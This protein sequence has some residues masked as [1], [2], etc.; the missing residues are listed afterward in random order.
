MSGLEIAG[1]I[2]AAPP[3]LVSW[4]EHYR[5]V[6]EYLGCWKKFRA[7]YRQCQTQ[8]QN[9]E[10]SLNFTLE[11]LYLPF[12]ES[13][14][15]LERLKET[16]DDNAWIEVETKLRLRLIKDAQPGYLGGLKDLKSAIQE[17]R[18]ELAY[19]NGCF[20][21][22]L[23]QASQASCQLSLTY[24]YGIQSHGPPNSP[25][26]FFEKAQ[27]RLIGSAEGGHTTWKTEKAP[28]TK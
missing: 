2:L 11:K 18:Q 23:S 22:E 21:A 16:P 6:F 20:Q 27:T 19:D 13:V 26:N 5:Q 4:L 28:G 3:L 1:V 17:L 25:S 15:E 14:T 24:T 12:V 10:L 8:V 7:E 9:L